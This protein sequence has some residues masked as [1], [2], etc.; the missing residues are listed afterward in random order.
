MKAAICWMTARMKSRQSIEQFE[1]HSIGH[2]RL[3]YFFFQARAGFLSDDRRR[4]E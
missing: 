3:K 4:F 1:I 2:F